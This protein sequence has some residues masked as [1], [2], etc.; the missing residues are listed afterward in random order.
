MRNARRGRSPAEAQAPEAHEGALVSRAESRPAA[1]PHADLECDAEGIPTIWIPN[2]DADDAPTVKPEW[3]EDMDR[4]RFGL[5][6]LMRV[7]TK[8]SWLRRSVVD[9]RFRWTRRGSFTMGSPEMEAGRSEDEGPQHHVTL[10]EGFWM[11]ETPCTQALWAAIMPDH[12]SASTA[13][14]RLNQPVVEV[15]WEDTTSFF[16]QVNDRLGDR[17][18]L[19]TE[20]QW[21]YASRAGTT[22]ATW[23][24]N[25]S[26][27]RAGVKAPELDAIAWYYANRERDV[28]E[29]ATK[30]ANPAG[31]YDMLGN[32]WEWCQD[33][34]GPYDSGPAID[35]MGP[36][37]G[38]RRVLR[39]G[40]WVSFARLVRAATRLADDPSFRLSY[41]GF[42]LSRGQRSQVAVGRSPAPQGPGAEPRPGAWRA[43]EVP[44]VHVVTDRMKAR[45]SII[46]R[47][48]WARRMG[49]DRY[50]LFADV[51]VPHRLETE[52]PVRFRLRWIPPGRFMMGSP[53]DEVG[54][55]DPA[56]D[57]ELLTD[58]DRKTVSPEDLGEEPHEVT[59][60]RGFWMADTP[61][62]QTL[63]TAVQESNPSTFVDLERPV[64]RVSWDDAQAFIVHLNERIS[65]LRLC[66]PSEAQWEYACR[67]G[68]TTATY[69]GD[70][71]LQGDN[72]A[73]VLDRI[74][75][76][77]GNSG[78]GYDLEDGYDSSGWPEKQ[79][80]H[81]KAGT[82]KVATRT[83]NAW[84][85]YDTLGNVWEWC[86]DWVGPYG[87]SAIEEDP[88][89]PDV[90]TLRVLRGGSWFLLRPLRA[91][92]VA[93]RARPVVP[94]QPRRFSF[95]PRSGVSRRGPEAPP[96]AL[97]A[98]SDGRSCPRSGPSKPA[99]DRP[100]RH[101]RRSDDRVR[102]PT[103]V[104]SIRDP[105]MQMK[106]ITVPVFGGEA[107][108]QV[109]NRFLSSHR[110]LSVER[111]LVDAGSGSAWAVC[112]QYDSTPATDA[113]S[114]V[115]SIKTKVDYREILS[116]S[117]FACY[118]RLRSLRKRMADEAGV[119]AYALFTNEQLAAIVRQQVTSKADLAKVAGIGAA[120][121][122]KYGAAFIE[123]MRQW[124]AEQR[125]ASGRAEND[126]Q[127]SNGASA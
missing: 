18:S 105:T 57:A 51:Q 33:W 48:E 28:E 25:L 86:Q 69:A 2:R 5:W 42:R 65:D 40:S 96:C 92:R 14:D 52:L 59:L 112:V 9:Y 111:R 67:G 11:G 126:L 16:G 50:G 32:V 8:R 37:M 68:T 80:D 106:F 39:G 88:T 61:V 27:D 84:G 83:P 44:S 76:Y 35:P 56:R 10:T 1:P 119:P 38:S 22:A 15:S 104:G 60:T 124:V 127:A 36:N 117:D 72:N 123:A 82:R 107:A 121:V 118:S 78:H 53:S 75:W 21:E 7:R 66:L 91:R 122:D 54:R 20:A 101:V 100:A 116:E 47:P 73:P 98:R 17:A 113:S 46:E 120:R 49:R 90:G 99:G 115:A 24:G 79:Y 63:W 12:P 45:L 31:L 109:L 102:R 62:T 58:E 110:V 43:R 97:P 23:V 95:V 71:D 41:V 94:R 87:S 70:L 81:A 19:P 26:L 77:G 85:L 55:W 114:K 34:Y 30:R 89:G 103:G 74:A 64:E 4:D 108:E 3:A 29:V 125:G 6:A 93:G 13:R